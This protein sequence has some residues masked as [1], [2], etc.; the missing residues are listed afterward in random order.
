[1]A[2]VKPLVA[3][4][5]GAGAGFMAGRRQDELDSERQEDRA[6]RK[7]VL[8]AQIAEITDARKLKASLADASRPATVE[9]GAGGMIRPETMDNRDVGLP[10][11]A[12]L[13]NGG[14]QTGGY[15]AAGQTFT[16]PA[17]A[18]AAAT[19]YNRPEARSTRLAD[20]YRGAGLPDKADDMEAKQAERTRAAAAYAKK[21]QDEGVFDA[22]QAFRNGDAGGLAKVFN[23][24]GQFKLEG[25]PVLTREN[26]EIPGVGTVPTYNATV[27]I[28]GPDG[29]VVEKTYNSHDISMS[30][31]PYEKQLELQRKG[32]ESDS[33]NANREA[34]IDVKMAALDA[35]TAAAGARASGEPTREERLR[36]TTLFSEAGRK[37]NEAQRALS[38]LQK[39]PMY[40]RAAKDTPRWQEMEELRSAIKAH[41][42]ERTMYQGLLANSQSGAR[43]LA[44]ARPG[45]PAPAE[46]A[47]APVAAPPAAVPLAAAAPRAAVPAA[48]KP[49]N[50]SQLWK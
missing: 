43:P 10:E 20:A 46:A 18:Q 25:D 24:S 19:T 49:G 36:Y 26:R 14:L 4:A 9:E 38:T 40:A 47:S 12:A 42:E 16:D 31:L 48:A 5:A 21:L 34:L 27:K 22:A 17:A 15:R 44:S 2:R 32:T 11:N 23:K 7:Q 41:N 50:Y 30:L 1:M 33:R 37:A 3:L 6:Q 39:D 29:T 35:K 8:D 13:P 45:A 28:K